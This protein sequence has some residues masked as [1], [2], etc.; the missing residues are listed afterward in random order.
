MESTLP[1]Q[2][3][4]GDSLS[5]RVEHSGYLPSDGWD[6]K[7][8]LL[9]PQVKPVEGAADGDGW[10]FTA[11]ASALTDL[12]PGLYRVRITWTKDNGDT[13]DTIE[14]GV[15]QVQADPATTTDGRSHARRALQAIEATL[16]GKASSGM[17]DM[18]LNDRQVR[19]FSVE[20]LLKLR[21]RYRAEVAAEDRA[22]GLGG[23]NRLT[24]R[25]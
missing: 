22:A 19:S 18:R 23:A 16:E 2:H 9:G 5:W 4:A 13:R 14:A 8:Y 21:D 7:A 10:I 11:A 6:A 20:E 1:R 17:L 3:T 25:L 15:L 12:D 24:V